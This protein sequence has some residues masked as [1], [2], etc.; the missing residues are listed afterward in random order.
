M[1]FDSVHDTQ[2]T[3]RTLLNASSYPGS[4]I[5]LKDESDKIDLDIPFSKGI[6][7]LCLTLLDGEVSFFCPDKEVSKI[8]SQ[9]TYSH[10]VLPENA[11][12]IILTSGINF[13]GLSKVA[14]KGTFI[15]PHSGATFIIEI[16][17]LAET[18]LWEL[19]GPGIKTIKRIGINAGFDWAE[20]REEAN[21]EFPL[22]LDLY[23]I[24]RKRQVLSLPRT[25]KIR[26]IE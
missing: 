4:I 17:S 18:G 7:L 5:S 9:M 6:M 26:R 10:P 22:G 11:D 8:I 15:D 3:F 2:K 1:K 25:T 19:S 13:A 20:L 16:D 23:F 21:K 24:D 14:G 12:F